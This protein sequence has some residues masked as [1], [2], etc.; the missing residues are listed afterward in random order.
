MAVVLFHRRKVENG[1][2]FIKRKEKRGGGVLKGE[3]CQ[4]LN[5][6]FVEAFWGAIFPSVSAE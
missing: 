3:V 1:K 5:Y 2:I 6:L 4:S